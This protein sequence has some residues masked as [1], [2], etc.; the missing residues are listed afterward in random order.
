MNDR[1]T[2]EYIKVPD[3]EKGTIYELDAR[4]FDIG[5]WDGERRFIG[6]RYKFSDIY[7]C[8]EIHW[9]LCNSFGTVRPYKAVGKVPDEIELKDS[10]PATDPET[11]NKYYCINADLLKYLAEFCKDDKALERAIK[12]KESQSRFIRED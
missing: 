8:G 7:P 12:S 4:N 3:L 10:Y 9:D 1:N 11:G 5:V 6:I 2:K